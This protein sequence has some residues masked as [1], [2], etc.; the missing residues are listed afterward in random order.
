MKLSKNI[1]LIIMLLV[2]LGLLLALKINFNYLENFDNH[3]QLS[4]V[5]IASKDILDFFQSKIEDEVMINL[6]KSKDY[7]TVN[8]LI[9]DTHQWC[10]NMRNSKSLST[11]CLPVKNKNTDEIKYFPI[12]VC[13]SSCYC[14]ILKEDTAFSF[15]YSDK[16]NLHFLLKNESVIQVIMDF[17]NEELGKNYIENNSEL[18]FPYITLETVKN[19]ICA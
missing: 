13:C 8:E 1:K 11:S 4:N 5:K 10:A 17:E 3:N 6:L 18:Y 12:S 15:V 9:T 7:Y 2:I 19:K 14:E 16:L